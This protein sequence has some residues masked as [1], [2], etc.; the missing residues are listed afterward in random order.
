MR[1]LTEVKATMEEEDAKAIVLNSLPSKYNNV[2]FTLSQMPSQ[3]LEDMISSLLVEENKTT[4]GD[5]KDDSQLEIALYSIYNCSKLAKDRGMEC[6]YCKKMR[7]S[8]EL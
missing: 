3:T 1:Q 7:H 5:T 8:L 4:T 2:I 6:Y